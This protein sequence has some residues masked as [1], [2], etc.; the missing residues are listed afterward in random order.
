MR[1]VKIGLCG[2]SIA[3]AEYPRRFPVVEVQQTFY[4]PPA[5]H[6][7]RRWLAATP[8]GFEFTIKAWQLITHAGGSPTY[9]RLRRELTAD[10]RA[11]VGNFRD[12]PIVAEGWDVTVACA[13]LLGATAIL[14]QCPASFR[15]TDE[16]V[17]NLD[18][19]LRRIQCP[20]GV[21]LMWEPRGPW[22]MD[23]VADV[24]ARHKL[25]HVV[26]PFVNAT[27]TRGVTYFRLHGISGARH[28]YTDDELLR[29]RDQIP[30][31]GETYV[32]FNNIPRAN[33]ARRFGR[34]LGQGLAAG[35]PT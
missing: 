26:D 34:L 4:Q 14:F 21:R 3:I 22:P 10:E 11:G 20:K 27:V 9:R 15:P 35:A 30:A 6:V 8:T 33:D 28:V 19:F 5:E 32:M 17:S 18:A 13:K 23:V 2:F 24:C 16:N 7:M 1:T 25:L 31:T 29:L 12:T